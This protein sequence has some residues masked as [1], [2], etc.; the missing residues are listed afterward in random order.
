MIM[1]KIIHKIA[2]L[3]KLNYGICDSFHT[4]DG[5]LMMSFKCSTCGKREG[6]HPVDEIVD[7]QIIEGQAGDFDIKKLEKFLFKRK[8]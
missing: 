4:K 3:L 2:H 6:I 8:N 5:R 7:N 1:K